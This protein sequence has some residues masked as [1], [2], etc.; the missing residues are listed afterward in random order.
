VIDFL[1]AMYSTTLTTLASGIVYLQTTAA[2]AAAAAAA[3]SVSA[4]VS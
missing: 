1:K 2:A 4:L 3:D